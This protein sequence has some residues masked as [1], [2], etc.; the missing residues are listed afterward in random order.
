MVY[1][2]INKANMLMSKN[3]WFYHQEPI[4][5]FTGSMDPKTHIRMASQGSRRLEI[6]KINFNSFMRIV[7]SVSGSYFVGPLWLAFEF[8]S[9]LSQKGTVP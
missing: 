2:A 6:I 5:S 1:N 9:P 8:T 4:G 7:G 3:P